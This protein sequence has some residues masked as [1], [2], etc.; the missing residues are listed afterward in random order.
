MIGM[1]IQAHKHPVDIAGINGKR[2]AEAVW[3][4]RLPNTIFST[5]DTTGIITFTDH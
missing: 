3:I 5:E 1:V 2:F 4:Y